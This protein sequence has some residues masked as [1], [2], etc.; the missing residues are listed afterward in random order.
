MKGASRLRAAAALAAALLAAVLTSTAPRA[1][2][3]AAAP[4]I[5]LYVLD[6]GV[7]KERD[8]VP[9]GLSLEQLPPRDLADLCVL[10]VHPRGT[11]LWDTGLNPSVND[12]PPGT[13]PAPG[14]P[15]AGDRVDRPL[16]AQLTAIGHPPASITYLA[17][18]H[19]HWDHT[20]NVRDFLATTW[21][22]QKAE[23]D[24]MFA[25]RP[26]GNR[27]DFAGLE[28]SKTQLLDGDHDVFGDG[29][30]RLILTPGHSPGHQALYVR[31]PKTGSVVLSGDLYHFPEELT[32]RPKPA[33]R[34]ADQIAASMAKLQALIAETGAQLW[35]QHD[36]RGYTRLKHAPA[37]Y[38]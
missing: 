38:D 26:L 7:M 15:R 20:G 11:L 9:Y 1:Q 29:S 13:K 19:S 32:L 2:S 18:S 35:I 14:A 36:I 17:L 37:Y 30:V 33:G 6:G 22:A 8:G 34:N 23:R 27:A 3:T 28:Q 16:A 10:V 12:T 4:A 31:L 5:R 24:V 25:E 21:L